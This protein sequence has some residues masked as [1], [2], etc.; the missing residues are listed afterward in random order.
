MNYLDRLGIS[1]KDII[2]PKRRKKLIKEI[3]THLMTSSFEEFCKG[4]WSVTDPSVLKWNWHM[5]IICQLLEQVS[6]GNIKNLLINVPPGS[7]KTKLVGVLWPTWDWIQRAD[8]QFI[9]TTYAANLSQKAAKGHRDLVKSDWFQERWGKG[10]QW[11]IYIDSESVD[12]KQEFEN[13]WMGSRFSTGVGGEVTGRRANIIIF[14]D[15]N[16]AQDATGKAGI[17]GNQIQKGVE[18]LAETLSTRTIQ[19]DNPKEKTAFVGICQRLH[20]ADV[21]DWCTKQDNW[22]HLNIPLEAME[23]NK[24]YIFRKGDQF[25]SCQGEEKAK[26]YKD[27]ELFFEDKRTEGELMFPAF[28]DGEEVAQL[29]AKLGRVNA[30]AQLQQ[31][32]TP[33]G[34]TLINVEDFGYWGAEQKETILAAKGQLVISVDA[35]FGASTGSDF[36]AIQV[37]KWVTG[38]QPKGITISDGYYF[39]EGVRKRIDF[40]DTVKEIDQIIKKYGGLKNVLIEKKAN[41]Q[42]IIDQMS[43]TYCNNGQIRIHGVNPTASKEG[44]IQSI[45]PIIQEGKCYLPQANPLTEQFL[46]EAGQFP[47]GKFDDMIDAFGQ[48]IIFFNSNSGLKS[49]AKIHAINRWS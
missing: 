21:A 48:A 4:A 7:A 26:E 12:R 28:M 44:R 43:R 16:K 29:K 3:E 46:T 45:S 9:Y 22:V 32:P 35:T 42:A 39:L 13:N 15:L 36:T 2:D 5:T 23:W 37:W 33:I 31:M 49:I 14:D 47:R 40:A 10:T 1:Q 20:W 24:T 17:V 6:K 41:G 8:R 19:T 11:N 30:A 38:Q 25:V 34:G 18:Y 27:W